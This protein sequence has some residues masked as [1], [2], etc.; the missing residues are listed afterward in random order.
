MLDKSQ[1]EVEMSG[2]EGTQAGHVKEKQTGL[3]TLEKSPRRSRE[4]AQC[5]GK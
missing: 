4:D 1:Q 3:S 2:L 5:P